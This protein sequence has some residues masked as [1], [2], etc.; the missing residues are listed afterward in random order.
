MGEGVSNGHSPHTVGPVLTARA[1]LPE[2]DRLLRQRAIADRRER[3]AADRTLR[4]RTGVLSLGVMHT[5]PQSGGPDEE[6]PKAAP[7]N[8]RE[9]LLSPDLAQQ[10]V[11]E[12]G[13]RG[14]ERL[15]SADDTPCDPLDH[16]GRRP[17]EL[18]RSVLSRRPLVRDFL[19]GRGSPPRRS[20]GRGRPRAVRCRAV[21]RKA[22]RSSA[23]GRP[24][25]PG[26]LPEA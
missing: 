19:R 20:V 7:T 10:R 14:K 3:R 24:R 17:P 26:G 9:R 18:H 6:L 25:P 22:S 23:R 2:D 8:R 1:S 5:D 21:R 12:G 11:A 15:A 4:K 13:L 16:V